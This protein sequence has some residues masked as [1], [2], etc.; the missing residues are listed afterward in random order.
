VGR[1]NR[2][3]DHLTLH[4]AD[5]ADL[6]FHLKNRPG[7]HVILFT[8]GQEASEEDLVF[9]AGLAAYYSSARESGRAEVDYT[10]A[11]NVKKP[12]G[13][14][15]G[16]VIYDRYKTLVVEPKDQKKQ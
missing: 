1:N 9:C 12:T 13:A 11:R 14:R 6:W 16:M 10:A 4:E 3:N 2:E 15:P 8:E 5:R 7:S